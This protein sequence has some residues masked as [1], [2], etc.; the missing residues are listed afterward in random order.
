MN[1][2]LSLYLCFIVHN[3]HFFSLLVLLL[4][5]TNQKFNK[6]C[7]QISID[8]LILDIPFIHIRDCMTK[9]KNPNKK[10]N[11]TSSSEKIFWDNSP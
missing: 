2:T 6:S 1:M 11:G 3:T 9:L 10:Y 8:A 4:D 7:M 5:S